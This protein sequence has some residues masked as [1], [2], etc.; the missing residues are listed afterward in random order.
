MN[1]QWDVSEENRCL[2]IINA[3]PTHKVKEIPRLKGYVRG[4]MTVCW[5]LEK[6]SSSE[7]LATFVVDVDPRGSVP[8]WAVNYFSTTLHSHLAKLKVYFEK[9]LK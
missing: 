9:N 2:V 4:E 1:V 7:T 8:S 6:S 3:M 5:L